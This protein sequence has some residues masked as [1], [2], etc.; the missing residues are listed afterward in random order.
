MYKVVKMDVQ[1]LGAL[2]FSALALA[3]INYEIHPSLVVLLAAVIGS[4]QA[5]TA[6]MKRGYVKGFFTIIWTFI[7]GVTAGLFLGK[8]VGTIIGVMNDDVAIILPIYIFALIGGRLVSW[9]IVDLD[10]AKIGNGLID[11]LT[12]K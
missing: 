10:V 11:R 4:I 5:T 2:L 12:K 6:R 9:L 3:G 7:A 8:A 1:I